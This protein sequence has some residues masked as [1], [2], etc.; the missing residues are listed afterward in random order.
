MALVI[1]TV[2]HSGKT[3]FF[4]NKIPFQV[5]KINGRHDNLYSIHINVVVS[6]DSCR[7]GSGI[8]EEQGPVRKTGGQVRKCPGGGGGGRSRQVNKK[9][10]KP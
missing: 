4:N 3:A 9:L 2:P 1:Y 5:L 10:R 6:Y 8:L 7:H